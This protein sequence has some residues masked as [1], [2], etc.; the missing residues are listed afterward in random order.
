M[1]DRESAREAMAQL[2]AVNPMLAQ[3]L[4]DYVQ[5]LEENLRVLRSEDPMAS[6]LQQMAQ[7]MGDLDYNVVR[8]SLELQKA[9][10]EQLSAEAVRETAMAEAEKEKAARDRERFK[11]RSQW[12]MVA[13]GSGG[14]VGIVAGQL[15]DLIRTLL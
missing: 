2:S 14:A 5:E 8:P 9:R 6:I 3:R 7:R 10:A 12:V 15:V 4:D 11:H 1:S 13:V